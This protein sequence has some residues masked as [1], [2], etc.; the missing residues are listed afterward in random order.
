[1]NEK[2]PDV[3]TETIMD[4]KL[5]RLR[6]KEGLIPPR[7]GIYLQIE[8]GTGEGQVFDLSTGGV[9]LIGR[10]GADVAIED[11]KVSRKHAEVGL[12]GPDA[13]ILR[14]LAST[15]GTLLNGKRVTDRV[16]LKHGDMIQVGETI[17]S[18]TV[19]Q[20][21]IALTDKR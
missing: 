8:K 15:N 11:S 21:S 1:M 9:Y 10:A 16:K 13:Y 6:L 17:I 4:P 5:A 3:G 20:G 14:D 2:K 18:F 12:Y 19:L 7:T